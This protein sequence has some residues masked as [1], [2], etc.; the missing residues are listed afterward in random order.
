[1]SRIT[2]KNYFPIKEIESR[3][4]G[5]VS[6][7]PLTLLLKPSENNGFHITYTNYNIGRFI[8][9]L[10]FTVVSGDTLYIAV[11]G[12]IEPLTVHVTPESVDFGQV[13]ICC[14]QYLCLHVKNVLTCPVRVYFK[15]ENHD[16]KKKDTLLCFDEFE[17]KQPLKMVQHYLPEQSKLDGSSI[18][19]PVNSLASF[20][21][22]Q[23]SQD[24]F[25]EVL[26]KL[27][28]EYENIKEKTSSTSISDE[29]TQV[30]IQSS[31]EA[32]NSI[33]GHVLCNVDQYLDIEDYRHN[34]ESNIHQMIDDWIEN[35]NLIER[36]LDEI[37]CELLEN[38]ETNY[39]QEIRTFTPFFDK[40][41]CL[42]ENTQEYELS[43]SRP[44]FLKPHEME[45]IRLNL[46]PNW[47]GVFRTHLKVFVSPT[48]DNPDKDQNCSNMISIPLKHD[49]VIPELVLCHTD[50]IE[51]DM[52]VGQTACNII[53]IRNF[54]D[55]IDGFLNA[56]PYE[57]ED[58]LIKSTPAKEIVPKGMEVNFKVTVTPY[59]IGSFQRT[60]EMYV[61][62]IDK[63]ISITFRLRIKPVRI[64]VDPKVVVTD[65][66]KPGEE[67]VAKFILMNLSPVQLGY[68]LRIGPHCN[69]GEYSIEPYDP[70][71]MPYDIV[72]LGIKQYFDTP[73]DYEACCCIEINE[74]YGVSNF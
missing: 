22:S 61:L 37:L 54:D 10:I 1:M 55:N 16:I 45:T 25:S 38:Y 20:V 72:E 5:E 53:R 57:S 58:L 27:L 2:Y 49:C 14:R 6:V 7:D 42:D 9:K 18:L 64:K 50:V 19:V 41:W 28:V 40:D 21:S 29:E 70:Y 48:D 39:D 33:L 73:G 68:H 65:N 63:P 47:P 59:I 4:G 36:L 11:T 69:L 23:V 26:E 56:P 46:I 24:E 12:K 51:L 13:S 44:L 71:L 17:A 31:V 67:T 32:V 15:L 62:G 30:S 35:K 3:F 34:L 8:E 66:V 74:E 43:V 60:Y 52:Y